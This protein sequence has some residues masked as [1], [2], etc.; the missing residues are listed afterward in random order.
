MK[1]NPVRYNWKDEEFSNMQFDKRTNWFI[2]Q[3]FENIIPELVDTNGDGYKG[4]SYEK[5]V[6]VLTKAIQELKLEN[7][8]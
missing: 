3:E 7:D 5:M 4:I 2:A 1:M 8:T 6:P